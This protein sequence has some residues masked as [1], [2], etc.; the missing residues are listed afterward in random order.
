MCI[1]QSEVSMVTDNALITERGVE[2]CAP[3]RRDHWADGT[4]GEETVGHEADDAAAQALGL[5]RR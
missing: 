5:S 3:P 4:V 2:A 1:N